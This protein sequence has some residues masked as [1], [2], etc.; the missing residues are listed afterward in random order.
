[1]ADSSESVVTIKDLW[2]E[3][4]RQSDR[5]ADAISSLDQTVA[6]LAG[7]L[8]AINT[9]NLAADRI[10]GDHEARLRA[11]ER[12]R[13]ALPASALIAAGSATAAVVAAIN[14][15]R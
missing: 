3:Q 7:H 5:L 13:Y 4:R 14:A 9:R 11:L 10:D 2:D 1:M 6:R 12:W 15:A 8:D